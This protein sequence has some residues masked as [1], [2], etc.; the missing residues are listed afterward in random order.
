MHF[1]DD[2]RIIFP[3]VGEL[4]FRRLADYFSDGWR[5]LCHCRF[6]HK[7][8]TKRQAAEKGHPEAFNL[9]D[10]PLTFIPLLLFHSF[11]FRCVFCVCR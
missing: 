7:K 5:M 1:S 8:Q 2:W 4:F 3:M 10:V 11:I 9:P 6:S